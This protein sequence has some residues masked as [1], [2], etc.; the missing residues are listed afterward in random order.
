MR[1]REV[2]I[3]DD[4]PLM[5]LSILDALT[6]EGY[7]VHEASNGKEGIE[8]L[9]SGRFDLVIT[10][11]KMPGSDGISVVQAC[12]QHSPG[13]EVLVITAH[14]SVD[15]SRPRPSGRRR[16]AAARGGST[17]GATPGTPT[18]AM[19]SAAACTVPKPSEATLDA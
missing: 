6:A 19:R 3:I 8:K 12:K 9:K 17:P 1:T 14:G 7:D 11:L 13:T 2:L 18:A 15:V 10:D 4:E 5:R 16:R